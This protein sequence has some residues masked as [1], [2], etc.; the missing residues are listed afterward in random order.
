VVMLASGRA[1]FF[2]LGAF[3]CTPRQIP[4]APPVVEPPTVTALAPSAAASAPPP[5]EPQSAPSVPPAEPRDL[6]L[7]EGFVRP[8]EPG[9]TPC[10]EFRIENAGDAEQLTGF[11]R[12]L[13]ADGAPRY[14]A[15]GIDYPHPVPKGLTPEEV[16]AYFG[17]R[18]EEPTHTNFSAKLCGDLTGDG[19]R[20]PGATRMVRRCA[21]LLA[22][23][24]VSLASPPR[25]LVSWA[26]G[27]GGTELRPVRYREGPAWQLLGEVSFDP[28][29]KT[30]RGDPALSH[31][32]IPFIPV[33]F[34][35]TQGRYVLASLSFPDA[36]A[37]HRNALRSDYEQGGFDVGDLD[38]IVWLDSLGAG[39][40]KDERSRIIDREMMPALD[41]RSREALRKLKTELGTLE[42]PV[43]PKAQASV[44][45]D[46]HAP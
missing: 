21:L 30:N 4:T 39:D 32:G 10:G 11:V 40:W 7:P 45:R 2:G 34:W 35:F 20:R 13:G 44:W 38:L 3:G 33:V 37:S 41:R 24:V 1:L 29:F 5:V 31:S 23:E 9:V 17:E 8:K 28:P 25:L 19:R 36:Y 16:R 15:H 12:V 18:P 22:L 42:A 46:V 26:M 6:D 27:D 14:E 43:R